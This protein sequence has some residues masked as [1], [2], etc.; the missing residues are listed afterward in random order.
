MDQK[1][2]ETTK[3]VHIS[4]AKDYSG[5]AATTEWISLKNY[6]RCR[7]IVDTGAW[8]AGTAAVTLKQAINVSGSSS[9]ALAFAEYWTGTGDTL[10]RTTATSNTFNLAAANTKYVIEVNDKQLSS[11]AGGV[12]RDCV[13]IAIGAAGGADFYAVVA[14]LYGA[15]YEGSLPTSI[16]D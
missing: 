8:A 5:A 11:T 15:R 2:T 12:K 16:T 1:L 9:A 7:F 14:E 4:G 6:S 10:T 3:I 13:S